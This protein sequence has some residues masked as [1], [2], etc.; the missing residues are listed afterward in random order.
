MY[1][2]DKIERRTGDGERE[3]DKKIA[4]SKKFV[5]CFTYL[6]FVKFSLNFFLISLFTKKQKHKC[7]QVHKQTNIE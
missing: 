1:R 7:W 5:V 2:A 4:F 6:I 3:R